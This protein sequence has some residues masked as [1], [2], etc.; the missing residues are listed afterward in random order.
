MSAANLLSLQNQRYYVAAT[1]YRHIVLRVLREMLVKGGDE[2]EILI[3]ACMLCS[4]EVR[5][6]NGNSIHS[7][8]S[9][10]YGTFRLISGRYGLNN[11]VHGLRTSQHTAM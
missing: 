8:V 2:S 9:G 11:R 10:D 5:E 3:L 4:S 1:E 6:R 7:L